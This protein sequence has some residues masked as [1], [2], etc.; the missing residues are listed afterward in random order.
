MATQRRNEEKCEQTPMIPS[1]PRN[2]GGVDMVDG[3]AGKDGNKDTMPPC[4]F[5]SHSLSRG[6]S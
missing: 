4:L 5:I 1:S 3:E 6:H 2:M